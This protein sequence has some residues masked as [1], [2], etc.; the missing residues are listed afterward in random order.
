MKDKHCLFAVLAMAV[1]LSSACLLVIPSEGTDASMTTVETPEIVWETEQTQTLYA[2]WE[3]NLQF[4][5]DPTAQGIVT[6][7]EGMAGAIALSATPSSDYSSV[8]WDF[9]DGTTSTNTYA[10]HYYGQPGTYVVKL[11]VFN[12]YGED[13]T[14]YIVEVPEMATGEGQ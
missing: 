8:L 7:I 12:N 14:E 5:T 6:P 10:T 9:G 11:T 2:K 4:T 3:G 1:M 13:T